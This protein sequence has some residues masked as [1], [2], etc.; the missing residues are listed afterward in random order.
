MVPSIENGPLFQKL[1][2]HTLVKPI[3]DPTKCNPWKCFQEANL[4]AFCAPQNIWDRGTCEWSYPA[5][6]LSLKGTCR[7]LRELITEKRAH[8]KTK[9]NA[10]Q[11]FLGCTHQRRNRPISFVIS[12]CPEDSNQF[13]ADLSWAGFRWTWVGSLQKEAFK[14]ITEC[15]MALV[16]SFLQLA[17]CFCMCVAISRNRVTNTG[18]A[19]GISWPCA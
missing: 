6:L 11:A 8:R 5:A 15:A 3:V 14:N 16:H 12:V 2:W 18:T 1:C 13:K 19:V 17:L 10:R 7:C 4:H 9:M